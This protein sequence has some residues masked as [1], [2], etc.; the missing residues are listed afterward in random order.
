MYISKSIKLFPFEIND[1]NPWRLRQLKTM[2]SCAKNK[3]LSKRELHKLY[4]PICLDYKFGGRT[5]FDFYLDEAWYNVKRVGL[6]TKNPDILNRDELEYLLI[7][8]LQENNYSVIVNYL[9]GKMSPDQPQPA[10][11]IKLLE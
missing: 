7:Y 2:F 6:N 8:S 1:K 9:K 4:G 10:P 5:N 3:K 11:Y